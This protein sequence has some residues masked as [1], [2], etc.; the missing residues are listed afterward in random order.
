VL[1]DGNGDGNG[2][3][4]LHYRRTTL[5]QNGTTAEQLGVDCTLKG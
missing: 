5:P 4:K 2:N 1:A 3:G